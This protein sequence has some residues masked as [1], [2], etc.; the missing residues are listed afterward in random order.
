MA[1][2]GPAALNSE[3]PNMDQPMSAYEHSFDDLTDSSNFNPPSQFMSLMQDFTNDPFPEEYFDSDGSPIAS[4]ADVM[5][6]LGDD[7]SIPLSPSDALPMNQVILNTSSRNSLADSGS[8]NGPVSTTVTS[9][10]LTSP[11]DGPVHDGADIKPEWKTERTVDGRNAFDGLGLG[12]AMEPHSDFSSPNSAGYETAQQL[13]PQTSHADSMIFGNSSNLYMPFEFKQATSEMSLETSRETSPFSPGILNPQSPQYF[14]GLPANYPQWNPMNMGVNAQMVP[15]QFPGNV[16]PPLSY[17]RGLFSQPQP[18]RLTVDP[19][20][21]KSRV[22]TQIPIKLNLTPLPPGIKKIHLPTHTISKPKLL[23]KPTP[24]PSPDMLELHVRLVCTSAMQN[25]DLRE[26]AMEQARKASKVPRV[27]PTLPSLQSGDG[28]DEG[29]KPQDGGEVTICSNCVSRERKRASRKKVRKPEDEDIWKQDELY[30]VIVFNTGE[31][32]E[33]EAPKGETDESGQLQVHMVQPGAPWTV[34]APMRIACY[35][36]H[37]TEKMGFQVIFTLTDFRGEFVAQAL[38]PSIMITDDHKTPHTTENA[39]SRQAAVEG[40]VFYPSPPLSNV[41]DRRNSSM[42]AQLSD[43]PIQQAPRVLVRPAPSGPLPGQQPSKKRKQ[44]TT[45]LET[46]L[47]PVAQLPVSAVGPSASS[48]PSPQYRH[49][50]PANLGLPPDGMFVSPTGTMAPGQLQMSPGLASGPPTPN[51]NQSSLFNPHG[52][53]SLD[54]GGAGLYSG[55]SS[56]HQSRAPSPTISMS[57][58]TM[59]AAHGGVALSQVA[60]RNLYASGPAN[61]VA[62][63]VS[64]T[65]VIHKVVPQEGS[66]M[67]GYEV[68]VLGK[69]FKMGVEVM[70]GGKPATTTTFWGPESLVCLVPPAESPGGVRIT[71]KDAQLE[72]QGHPVWFTYKEDSEQQTINLAL[73]ILNSKINGRPGGLYGFAQQILGRHQESQGG[74]GAGGGMTGGDGSYTGRPA[75]ANLEGQLLNVLEMID[76]DDSPHSARFNLRTRTT[77]Q[78]ALHIA[79][80]LGLQRFVAGL[81]ARGANPDVRDKAGYTALH[82]ASLM[83]RP[84]IIRLLTS[85]GADSTLRTLSGLSAADMAKSPAAIQAINRFESH[86]RSRSGISLHSRVNSAL[87]LAK[88]LPA[89]ARKGAES[90]NSLEVEADDGEESPEYSTFA[91]TEESDAASD[92]ADEEEKRLDMRENNN[93]TLGPPADDAPRRQRRGTDGLGGLALPTAAMTAFRDHMTTQFQQLQQSMQLNI[94]QNLPMPY[95]PQ[96]PDYQAAVTQRLVTL[97]PSLSFPGTDSNVEDFSSLKEFWHALSSLATSAQPTPTLAPPAYDEIFQQ[98]AHDRKESSA[99][100]AA[101]EAEADVKC[102]ALYDEA[103]PSTREVRAVEVVEQLSDEEDTALIE[104]GPKNA[105][106]EAQQER[107][108]RA[109]AERLKKLSS[110]KKLYTVWIPLLLVMIGAM[111]YS[112]LPYWGSTIREVITNVHSAYLEAQRVGG[113]PELCAEGSVFYSIYNDCRDCIRD[114]SDDDQYYRA[115]RD[116]LAPNFYPWLDYCASLR[117][118]QDVTSIDTPTSIPVAPTVVVEPPKS[119][120]KPVVDDGPVTPPQT[121]GVAPISSTQPP[122]Q[123]PIAPPTGISISSATTNSPIP[124]VPSAPPAPG[125]SPG[126]STTDARGTAP[127]STSTSAAPFFAAGGNIIETSFSTAIRTPI[128]DELE[129]GASKSRDITAP[130]SPGITASNSERTVLP[131]PSVTPST[132]LPGPPT[133]TSS[134]PPIPSSLDIP[135]LTG[136]IAGSVITA[137]FLLGGIIYLIRSHRQRG[138]TPTSSDTWPNGKAQLHSRSLTPRVPPAGVLDTWL[139]ELAA[140]TSSRGSPRGLSYAEMGE[141]RALRELREL[142]ELCEL[143]GMRELAGSTGVAELEKTCDLPRYELEGGGERLRKERGS[144]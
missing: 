88:A 73:A 102:A 131:N 121:P 60:P 89:P 58:L 130:N 143:R 103:G 8:S 116:Y 7:F 95:I 87:N 33:W 76:L 133:S 91:T 82:M 90:D 39:L 69:G 93:A 14:H 98:D 96:I 108:R 139:R 29:P 79:C 127:L 113:D 125:I 16:G 42:S 20:P 52:T 134:P 112:S 44:A 92:N 15:A 126:S 26:A 38:S 138:R 61:A 78:T 5:D 57:T 34:E 28:T 85:H 115:E 23:A 101:A 11:K 1:T 36:R 141:L 111:F 129:D 122:N 120:D 6:D 83:N 55:T 117:R 84:D 94:L 56:L 4:G 80:Y 124:G 53:T 106:T 41:A 86:T 49:M 59:P 51:H 75:G 54:S 21:S 32:R 72:L 3:L 118:G 43:Q 100:Q 9:T 13:S 105:I 71:F 22:E 17:N 74:F 46:A 70:F 132:S 142:R 35:C 48:T 18:F 119:T 45:R 81:L 109:R 19:T 30:R 2:A 68:T 31:I 104:I 27:K 63:A 123:A 97:M 128:S 62:N 10:S 50:P 77:G 135:T 37:H 66:V 47:S 24:E 64:Q 107:I 110:D 40:T 25:K 65:P 144:V 136:I 137:L 114:W 67:G 99:A 12:T 140:D